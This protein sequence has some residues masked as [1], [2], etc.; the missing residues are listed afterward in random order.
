MFKK[1]IM[2]PDH[3]M[4]AKFILGMKYPADNEPQHGL[5]DQSC[6][7]FPASMSKQRCSTLKQWAVG[8]TARSY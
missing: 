5:H 3:P 2:K 4:W 8:A 6:K 7:P 1:K